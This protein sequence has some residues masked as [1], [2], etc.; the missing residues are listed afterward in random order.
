MLIS[1]VG[2]FDQGRREAREPTACIET[3]LSTMAREL[4]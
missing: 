1:Y 2:C 4:R 3:Q